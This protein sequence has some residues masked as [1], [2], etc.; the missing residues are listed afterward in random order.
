MPFFFIASR[1]PS[2]RVHVAF[3]AQDRAS[4]DAFHRA[5]IAAGGTDDGAPGVRSIYHAYYY[6]AFVR[7]PDGNSIETVCHSSA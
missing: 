5:V 7:D 2:M 1:D 6:G 4:C 3:A